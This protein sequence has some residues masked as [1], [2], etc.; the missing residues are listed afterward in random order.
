MPGLVQVDLSQCAD[1]AAPGGVWTPVP[2][3]GT[4][5]AIGDAASEGAA[6]PATA[7]FQWSS[8]GDVWVSCAVTDAVPPAAKFIR[9]EKSG[10]AERG[11]CPKGRA[12]GIVFLGAVVP[13]LFVLTLHALRP[14]N[15]RKQSATTPA[16][17]RPKRPPKRPLAALLS[18]WET[19]TER[20]EASDVPAQ[21]NA[22]CMCTGA[23]HSAPECGGIQ[24]GY[25]EPSAVTWRNGG[26]WG[27]GEWEQYRQCKL[28]QN[29]TECPGPSDPAQPPPQLQLSGCTGNILSPGAIAAALAAAVPKPVT[30]WLI[31]ESLM[32]QV[33]AAAAC[34]SQARGATEHSWR[35]RGTKRKPFYLPGFPVC[36]NLGPKSG[37]LC[38]VRI[39]HWH[40]A[41]RRGAKGFEMEMASWARKQQVA[42]PRHPA[43]VVALSFGHWLHENQ[44]YRDA[45]EAGVRW[46][47]DLRGSKRVSRV[48]FIE[49]PP[50][51]F[52][53]PDGDF[54]AWHALPDRRGVA[55]S[56]GG[57]RPPG[58]ALGL[59]YSWHWLARVVTA[60]HRVSLVPLWG[61]SAARIRAAQDR[62]F[63]G[64]GGVLR[65]AVDCP[66]A[67]TTDQR[68]TVCPLD[69][70]HYCW[71]E[72]PLWVGTLATWVA[73]VRPQAVGPMPAPKA[74]PTNRWRRLR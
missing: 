38:I 68:Y 73:A 55:R 18:S 48:G 14:V 59:R 21:L 22:P 49:S 41:A 66:A 61:P 63:T 34:L 9:L 65:G 30:V 17:L 58:G 74:Y 50:Q 6:V 57:C 52:P 67:N 54:D 26:G 4:F 13:P 53:V 40:N 44:T 2:D 1:S 24:G 35:N 31:G 43:D 12:R 69:C 56:A 23:D 15:R 62:S 3:G 33:F 45:L 27:E 37:R 28:R 5:G 71:E 72:L 36:A 46:L 11:G 8:K 7:R 25:W 47:A 19:V 51:G 70:T 32:E 16:P 64:S 42:F 39:R 29:G 60:Q 20:D 10:D